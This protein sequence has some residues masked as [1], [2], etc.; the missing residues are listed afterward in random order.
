[1][2]LLNSIFCILFMLSSTGCVKGVRTEIVQKEDYSYLK[3]VG[4]LDSASVIIDEGDYS[5]Q[6]SQVKNDNSLFKIDTGK[7]R[8]QFYFF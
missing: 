3:F 2:I 6:L 4:S 1:M 5:F 7:H 8:I